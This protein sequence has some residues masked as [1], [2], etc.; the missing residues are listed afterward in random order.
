MYDPVVGRFL[1]VDELSFAAGDPNLYR[2]VGNSPTNYTDPSGDYLLAVNKETAE[3]VRERIR[4][5][6]SFDGQPG[7]NAPEPQPLPPTGWYIIHEIVDPDDLAKIHRALNAN[8]VDNARTAEEKDAFFRFLAPMASNAK[9]YPG[10][11][12]V[13]HAT[14][15]GATF[16]HVPD[17]TNDPVRVL[18]DGLVSGR[19]LDQAALERVERAAAFYRRLKEVEE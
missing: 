15:D 8:L 10:A 12:V 3:A 9:P 4:E 17:D 16:W 14:K 2:Y 1:E 5:V 13:T 11:N 19:G 6:T 18:I 7:V